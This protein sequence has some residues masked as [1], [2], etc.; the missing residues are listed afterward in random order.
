MS[1]LMFKLLFAAMALGLLVVV[2]LI[3]R[4]I[5][6]KRQPSEPKATHEAALKAPKLRKPTLGKKESEPEPEEPAS[7]PARRRQLQSFAEAERNAAEAETVVLPVAIP[8]PETQ[9]ETDDA[10]VMAGSET[11]V[12][13]APAQPEA[14][15]E[16]N[17]PQA[18][19]YN[20]VVL[21]RLEE[22]FEALQEG[23][24]TLDAYHARIQA[25]FAAVEEHIA[26]L[27]GD[28]DSAD[29]E[30]ALTA[31]EAVLWCLDWAEEQASAES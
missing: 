27:E 21:G 8:E 28:G 13:V 2:G 16:A 5:M 29:L 18:L 24:L 7:A 26:A 10:D 19:D 31:R 9:A 17:E 3:V 23:E 1:F 15:P 20:E 6:S 14:E 25:E 30:T 22:A 4:Q 11:E 12:E